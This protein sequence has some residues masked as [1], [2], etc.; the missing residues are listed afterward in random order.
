MEIPKLITI[1]G[2]TAVGKTRLAAM[3][4]YAIGGEIIS[5]DSRQVYQG[6]DIGTGKDIIDY[7]VEG[8]TVPFHLIDVVHP[9]EDFNVFKFKSLFLQSVEKII[10]NDN[11]PIM[12]GGTGLYLDAVLRDYFFVE[13]PENIELRQQLRMK[14]MQELVDMLVS[15]RHVHNKTDLEDRDRLTRAIEIA[16]FQNSTRNKQRQIDITKS[17]VFGI[18]VPR[19]I[20]RERIHQRLDAR[21]EEGMVGEI[22]ALLKQGVSYE[23]LLSFGLEYRYV[24]NYLMGNLSMIE[25]REK[26]CTAIQ[27]FAKRQMS[28]FRRMQRMGVDIEWIDGMRTNEEKAQDIIKKIEKFV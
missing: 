18:H 11:T 3:L 25:M 6:M 17:F 8:E 26:L 21:L 7:E 22:E 13:V 28:W 1:L 9:N 16:L 12:C 19:Q 4:A 10:D 24:T 23:R 15:M 14:S 5:A 20:I 2:P 27:Q